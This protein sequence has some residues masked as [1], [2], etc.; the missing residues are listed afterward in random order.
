MPLRWLCGSWDHGGKLYV[1]LEE[2]G[3]AFVRSKA[4]TSAPGDEWEFCR[5]RDFGDFELHLAREVAGFAPK[6]IEIRLERLPRPHV[7]ASW[8]GIEG[9]WE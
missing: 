6:M 3:K 7:V 4:S 1:W 2:V 5:V 8:A 9:L